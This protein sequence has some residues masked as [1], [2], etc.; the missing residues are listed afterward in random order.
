MK[1]NVT[2]KTAHDLKAEDQFKM[3]GILYRIDKVRKS[4]AEIEINFYPSTDV[5]IRH[6]MS[7]MT[8]SEYVIFTVHN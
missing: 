8:V 3:G 7:K 4:F 6:N 5:P 2:R 1:S